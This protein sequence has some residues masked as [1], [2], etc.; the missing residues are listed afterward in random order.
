MCTEERETCKILSWNLSKYQWKLLEYQNTLLKK[1]KKILA[2]GNSWRLHFQKSTEEAA[3]RHRLSAASTPRAKDASVEATLRAVLAGCFFMNY[4]KRGKTVKLKSQLNFNE[5][6]EGL[7]KMSEP[8]CCLCQSG[9]RTIVV[10]SFPPRFYIISPPLWATHEIKPTVQRSFVPGPPAV[11][12]H[13]RR[14]PVCLRGTSERALKYVSSWVNF[15]T[16]WL[17]VWLWIQS[18]WTGGGGGSDLRPD[19][20]GVKKKCTV[21]TRRCYMAVLIWKLACH[22]N[23]FTLCSTHCSHRS[24]THTT[25]TTEEAGNSS[26]L[27]HI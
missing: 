16:V 11:P 24:S 21:T 1:L 13:S 5:T 18:W 3:K 12:T 23:A 26:F 27:E 7:G 15:P 10:F 19:Y 22:A 20:C 14:R 9:T 8:S 2:R 4:T 6:I 25:H 17:A